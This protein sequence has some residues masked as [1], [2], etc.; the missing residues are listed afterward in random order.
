M[1]K[2]KSK[3]DN[4]EQEA[5]EGDFVT[6][7]LPQ[8]FRYEYVLYPAGKARRIPRALAQKA[9]FLGAES[10]PEAASDDA[11]EE[12]DTGGGTG[13]EKPPPQP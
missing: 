6:V 2:R 11:S 4:P 9:G 12:G 7:D 3:Q 5:P 1:A 13:S 8:D 10:A